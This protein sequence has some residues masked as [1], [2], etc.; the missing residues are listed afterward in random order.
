MTSDRG[1]SLG[2][3]ALGSRRTVGDVVAGAVSPNG[4]AAV[5]VALSG[6]AGAQTARLLSVQLSGQQPN[7]RP[8]PIA[9][10]LELHWL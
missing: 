1:E 2:N 7:V 6:R 8:R 9:N 10:L 3:I 5:Y 4:R